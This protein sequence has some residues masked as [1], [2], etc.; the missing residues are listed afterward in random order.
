MSSASHGVRCES[1]GGIHD[2]LPMALAIQWPYVI[3]ELDEEERVERVEHDTD[4]CIFDGERFFL[5]GCLELRVHGR[6]ESPFVWGVWVELSIDDFE[7]TIED[8][9]TEGR[10]SSPP[11][12]GR[13]ANAIPC[14]D[15]G[16]LGL[17]VHLHT[18]PVGLRPIVDLPP[19]DHPLAVEQHEGITLE[20][21]HAIVEAC[22]GFGPGA[23]LPDPPE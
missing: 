22:V 15:G 16:T 11:M 3:H 9:E 6:T 19:V 2:E 20:R 13:L 17:P 23:G 4:W 14:Y 8:W 1:C 10:E 18:R 7:A 21:V 5:R 12:L